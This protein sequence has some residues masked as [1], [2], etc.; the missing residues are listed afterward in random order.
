MAKEEMMIK[1][2]LLNYPI[3][4]AEQ[5]ISFGALSCYDPEMP[6]LGKSIKIKERV[7]DVGHHTTFQH[8]HYSFFIEG[9][10][11]SDI[12][13]GLHMCSPFYNS[14]QR[15]GRFCS[16]MFSD[17]NSLSKIMSYVDCYYA[18]DD[19]AL[20]SIRDYVEYCLNVYNKNI[21]SAI[22]VAKK[23]IKEERP[24]ASEEYVNINAKKIAQEQMRVF[25]PTIF[26]TGIYFTVNLSALAA[27]YYNAWSSVLMEVTQE[28]VNL[29]LKINPQ[30]AFAFNRLRDINDLDLTLKEEFFAADFWDPSFIQ[31]LWEPKVDVI[32]IGNHS[33][34]VVPAEEDMFPI[35]SLPF[36]PKYMDNNC[37]EIKTRVK[38]SL[39]TMGQ[40]QRHR[41]IRRGK[42]VFT[43]NFYLPPIPFRSDELWAIS[44][45]VMRRWIDL[46]FEK[47][48]PIS[49]AR[50]L[51]P[52][53]A[54][55]SYEK[56]ASYNAF[57]HEVFK[58][59]CWCAQEE[60]YHVAAFTA[61]K[62]IE[63][64]GADCSLLKIMMPRCAI[65]GICAE[66]RRYC[67]RDILK[68]KEE[69]YKIRKV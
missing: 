17:P 26:P 64:F 21:E 8:D 42:P 51:A 66:G 18:L 31:S 62:I 53:G 19:H 46:F 49:L 60:I 67:G 1:V 32:S 4:K 28:M 34:F 16:E 41:T 10:A 54:V 35:D 20:H 40:D 68:V 12:T 39:A 43:G 36:N 25:I 14:G 55:V 57:A 63:K 38:I 45:E 29:V 2:Q 61:N 13:L 15:S 50:S 47:R 58:R 24:K 23:F 56:S 52:Y 9:I 6:E 33:R 44:E 7:F 22:E 5:S 65:N 37:E 59:L 48:I 11:V 69:I 3:L 27:L 30:I